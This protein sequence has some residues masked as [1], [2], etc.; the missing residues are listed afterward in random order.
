[1]SSRVDK[2]CKKRRAVEGSSDRRS[3]QPYLDHDQEECEA[4]KELNP[5]I[6]CWSSGL[7]IISV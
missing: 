3:K 1:M 6:N 4:N 5:G 7:G 2:K